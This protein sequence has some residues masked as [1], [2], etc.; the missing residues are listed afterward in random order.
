MVA[1][2]SKV[3]QRGRLLLQQPASNSGAIRPADAGLLQSAVAAVN[4]VFAQVREIQ[5][6]V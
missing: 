1:I 5:F 6:G 4:W 3:F 2:F